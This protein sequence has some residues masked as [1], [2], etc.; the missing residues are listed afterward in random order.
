MSKDI[1]QEFQQ[2]QA[3][4]WHLV[5]N[6]L[7]AAEDDDLLLVDIANL[8]LAIYTERKLRQRLPKTGFQSF[9]REKI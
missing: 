9:N 6:L 1:Y 8:A 3:E 2:Q 7:G 5:D 4:R